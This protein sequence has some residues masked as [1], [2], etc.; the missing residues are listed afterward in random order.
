MGVLNRECYD[1]Y[2][3]PLAT[4][5]VDRTKC[6]MIALEEAN[7]APIAQGAFSVGSVLTHQNEILSTGYSRELEGNTHAEANAIAK[8][9]DKSILSQVEL[10]TT[11][12]PC[13]VFIGV[14]EPP[15]FVNCQGV[16]KLKE[17]GVD[18]IFL[19]SEEYTRQTGRNLS[20]DCLIAARRS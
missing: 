1:A 20:E 9:Q 17:A 6:I 19:S 2:V 15:D 13:T 16:S 8:V 11:L 14:E 12:E 3:S 5:S 18:V 10:Y 7:K 4:M